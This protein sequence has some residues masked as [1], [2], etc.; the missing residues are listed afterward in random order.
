MRRVLLSRSRTCSSSVGAAGAP[1]A[2]SRAA[3]ITA[4]KAQFGHDIGDDYVLVNYT[5][6]V[7]YLQKLDRESDRM[8]VVDIGKTAEG[9]HGIHRDR[10]LSREPSAA[11]PVQGHQPAAGPGRGC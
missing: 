3:R 4:P 6:Y 11:R 10:H 2:Q 7:E 1:T 9:R 8:T 5:R